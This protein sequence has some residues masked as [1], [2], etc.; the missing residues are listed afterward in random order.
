MPA[1]GICERVLVAAAL[2]GADVEH[3]R[4]IEAAQALEFVDQSEEVV[5]VR[6]EPVIETEGAE[7]V[8]L[9]GAAARAE[10]GEVGVDAAVVLGDGPV[11]VVDDDERARAQLG[12]V[13]ES[14]EGHAARKRAVADHGHHVVVLAGAVTGEGEAAGEAH[15]GR[16]VAH[17]E[18]VV[19]GLA[20]VR[21]SRGVRVAGGI[22][23]RG[24]AAGEH[25]VRIGLVRDVE[26]DPIAWGLEDPVKGHGE[27][28]DA[29]VGADV[30]ALGCGFPDDGA[31]DLLAEA[32][33]LGGIER[34]HISW[35][36][37]PLEIHRASLS[38]T[39]SSAA[40]AGP[41]TSLAQW[42]PATRAIRRAARRLRPHS[43]CARRGDAQTS[44]VC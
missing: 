13:V 22:G 34:P 25:L 27:L 2:G 30:P 9:G 44:P 23:E 28:D 18:Q 32:R 39:A 33:Q 21:K 35:G 24:G 31:T 19:H 8:A 43:T 29:Q 41:H 40:F 37:D 26:E 42:C 7:N 4:V 6:H 3:H 10:G 11:V 15:R 1:L 5:A 38:V 12:E 36:F 20:G 17:R 16:G 14:L